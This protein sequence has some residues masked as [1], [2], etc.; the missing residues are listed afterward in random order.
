MFN[1]FAFATD[2]VYGL[3][4]PCN[5]SAAIDALYRVK[6]RPDSQPM[7]VLVASRAMAEALVHIAPNQPIDAETRIYPARANAAID[8]RLIAHGGIGVR[9]PNHQ[10]LQDYI[11][12][13]GVALAASSANLRGEPALCS[14][15][16]VKAVFPDIPIV[17]AGHCP[18]GTGSQ[19]WDMREEPPKRLR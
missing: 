10:A 18:S 11:R 16:A 14:A 19:L 3:G 2:T 8:P 6:D 9:L 5:D 17:V 1:I 12:G 13:L 15:E 4:A 7:Q